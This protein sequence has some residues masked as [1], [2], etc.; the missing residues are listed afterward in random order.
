MITSRIYLYKMTIDNGGAPCVQ[1]HL[2]SLAICKPVIRKTAKT[3]DWLL[4]VGGKSLHNRLIYMAEVTEIIEY[5]DYY[6]LGVYEGRP[7][8]IY[9]FNKE[10]KL[11]V[12]RN[13]RYHHDGLSIGTDVG[14]QDAMGKYPSARVLLSRNYRYPGKN[15]TTSLLCS[16]PALMEVL[17]GLAQGHCVNHSPAVLAELNALQSELW[18]K[19]LYKNNGKPS[20]I[21]PFTNR[22]KRCK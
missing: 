5:G 12:R 20:D 21:I 22:D 15:G 18:E 7:D 16:Y 6:S 9:E 17:D 10:G 19:T 3:G 13:A 8:C 1:N 14:I 4:G 11:Q 2:L